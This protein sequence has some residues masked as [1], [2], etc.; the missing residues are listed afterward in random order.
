MKIYFVSLG[1]DK[2]LVDSE[3][4]LGRLSK[5]YEITNE[6]LE[7]DIAIVNTCA[8]IR[9]AKEESIN[10]IIELSG[11]KTENLKHLF[12]T[13]CLSQRYHEDLEGLIPEIDGFVGIS[14]T[15]RIVEDIDR[16]VEGEKVMD[17][18]D[19]NEPQSISSVRYMTPPYHT[20]YL[21]I[22]EGCDKHCTYCSI[23]LIR[24]KFRSIPMEELLNEADYLAKNGVS[25][26]ILIAQETTVY[27]TDLY[28]KKSLVELVEKLS[29]IEELKWIR[30]MYCY[31]EEIDD[32]LI[33]L[34]ANNPKVCHYLDIPIQHS[35]DLILQKM[36]RRTSRKDLVDIIS[37][38]RSK[39]PDI[40]L[41]TSLIAGFPGE[42][43]KEFADVLK[44]VKQ[45]KFDRLGV[46]AYSR[47]E[48]TPAYKF[49]N[50]VP[51]KIKK[52]RK[53]AIME[54]QSEIS[55]KKN[56][57]MVG[58]KITVIIDGF[59]PDNNV[60][61]GRSYKDAPDVDGVVFI[62]G[63]TNLMSG[64]FVKVKITDYNE[65]DLIGEI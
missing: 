26:L 64:D 35:S 56:S 45:I 33:D 5:K 12:I 50:Q 9:D 10:T 46:F 11:L 25:E 39:V 32:E 47:E 44:F 8:F 54:L 41:R 60:F 18:P 40:A 37:K 62:K 15:D 27:G 3:H 7:A 2:N 55:D 58:K 19:I 21:K 30:L 23:P 24:G 29:E 36:G 42:T 20:A 13:G 53:K 59:D 4:M 28:G 63:G 48:G 14:A 6:P 31:P 1:C 16:V 43:D 22:A 17:F 65:Y 51:Q 49:K 57:K 52:E 61:V 34:I 38:L